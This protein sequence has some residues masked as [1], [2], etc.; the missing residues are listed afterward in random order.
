MAKQDA[1]ATAITVAA[2]TP[3]MTLEEFCVRLSD[4]KVDGRI[5]LI[6][7]FAYTERKSGHVKDSEANFKARLADFAS[8]P[9]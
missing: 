2:P 5:A 4:R 1:D 9:V 6:H 3:E 8:K 7:G